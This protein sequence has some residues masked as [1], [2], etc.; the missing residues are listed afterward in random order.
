MRFIK[1]SV[2]Q[3]ARAKAAT[4]SKHYIVCSTGG[5]VK[6]FDNKLN[7]L[8][9]IK[10][11][12]YVYKCLIS[13]D[14]K[15]LLLISIANYFYIVELDTFCITKHTIKGKYGDNLEGKGCWSPDGN[16]CSFCVTSKLEVRSALRIY[17][18]IRKDVYR[19]LLCD[20]YWLTSILAIPKR[21]KYLL[22]GYDHA[23]DKSYLIW[24]DGNRFEEFPIQGLSQ[25]NAVRHAKFD[26]NGECCIV[27]GSD[28]TIFCTT[29]GV[30]IKDLDLPK[31]SSKAFS[32]MDIFKTVDINE[33]SRA[34][35][36]ALSKQYGFEKMNVPD[37]IKDVCHSSN[38]RYFYVATL[39]RLLCI[40]AETHKIEAEKEYSFG[41]EAIEE[42]REDLLLVTTWDS[43]ELLRVDFE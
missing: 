41:V 40:D 34:K 6:I 28:S 8:Q 25:C 1:E 27:I 23:N 20:K 22:T 11:V 37:E 36:A 12:R 30:L 32:F 24:Y 14:E 26:E 19:D 16:G 39:G 5:Q 17:D 4:C 33:E 7:L 42:I 13:P 38:G 35:I 29:E 18:D 3:F 2:K 9:I 43:V 10:G 31:A 15:K 21:N